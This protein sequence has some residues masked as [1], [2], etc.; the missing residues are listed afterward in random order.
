MHEVG[1]P[2]G[3]FNLVHG[4]GP[5]SAGEFLTRNPD[6]DAITFTGESRTGAT[7]MKVAA[8]GVRDVSFELGGK[9]AAVV[10]ADCDFDAAGGP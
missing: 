8:E 5:N 4:F 2:A 1:L 3:V 7:I 6:V 9:N 10:F